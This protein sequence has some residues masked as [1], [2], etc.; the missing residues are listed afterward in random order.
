MGLDSG[1]YKRMLELM[2]ELER[3]MESR[4][5][6]IQTDMRREVNR[7]GDERQLRSEIAALIEEKLVEAFDPR[8]GAGTYG[9]LVSRVEVLEKAYD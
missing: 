1:Q 7:L 9:K 5:A 2:L 3:K 4:F 8:A 6:D